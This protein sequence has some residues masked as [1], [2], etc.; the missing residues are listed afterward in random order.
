MVTVTDPN[1]SGSSDKVSVLTGDAASDAVVVE[2]PSDTKLLAAAVLLERPAAD[3]VSAA[4][5]T[6]SAICWVGESC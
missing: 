6:K 3:T 4:E 2:V 1:A 5:A